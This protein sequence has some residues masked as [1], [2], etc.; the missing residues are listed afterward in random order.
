MRAGETES[1]YEHVRVIAIVGTAIAANIRNANEELH[2]GG[3]L[4][5]EPGHPKD[6][7]IEWRR[8]ESRRLCTLR[9]GGSPHAN[10]RLDFAD[11]CLT[12]FIQGGYRHRQRA[13]RLR[14][15]KVV[16]DIS[17]S[18]QRAH[19]ISRRGQRNRRGPTRHCLWQRLCSTTHQDVL[20]HVAAGCDRNDDGL[21]DSR[22]HD[23][24]RR[25]RPDSA[26]PLRIEPFNRQL[27][28]RAASVGQLQPGKVKE[29]FQR[30]VGRS[31][32]RK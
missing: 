28:L 11:R 5:V 21:K 15:K 10:H 3:D 18:T 29:S 6:C 20:Q 13:I 1:A 19:P 7:L 30:L 14:R 27:I 22:R 16:C 8:R 25:V 26:R 2:G 12:A 9:I 23:R 4:S 24:S 17:V 32:F 31:P